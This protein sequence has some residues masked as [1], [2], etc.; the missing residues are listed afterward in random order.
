LI[1][2]LSLA[3]VV[4][5]VGCASTARH[6]AVTTTYVNTPKGLH[7]RIVS[8]DPPK[9]IGPSK[10]MTRELYFSDVPGYPKAVFR[11]PC[12]RM[13][14]VDPP[15]TSTEVCEGAKIAKG[16]L[17]GMVITPDGEIITMPGF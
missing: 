16:E 14:E 3:V 11:I 12:V 15:R 13:N 1:R 5:L 17:A 9:R 8:Y 4:A 7:E 2:G 10:W 6:A